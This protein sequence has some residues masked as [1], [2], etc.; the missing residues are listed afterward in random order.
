MTALLQHAQ[1]RALLPPRPEAAHKGT[2]G[3]VFIIAGSRGF[4]GAAKLACRAAERSGVGLVTL[5]IAEK[6]LDTVATDL[7]ETM[8]IPLPSGSDTGLNREAVT[9]ALEF[10]ANIESVVLGPGMGT[11]GATQDFVEQF[12]VRCPV[13]FVADAD[14]LN[15]IAGRADILGLKRSPCI[16]TPHPGEMARLLNWDTQSVQ[17]QR[18]AAVRKMADDSAGVTILKGHRTLITAPGAPIYENATG[19]HGL[20]KGGSG[21]VLSGLLGG[22]LAQGMSP[23]DAAR[24]GVYVHGL[25]GDIAAARIGTRGMTASDVIAAIPAAWRQ[26][27]SQP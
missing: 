26:L 19:N 16:L 23:L 17:A 8:T 4:T 3:H 10:A 22:L 24:L 2:F 27:E 6:L 13:P 15:G 25:A 9:S 5:G 7:S 11:R 14:A 20:A 21:D 18:E 12:I 1:M